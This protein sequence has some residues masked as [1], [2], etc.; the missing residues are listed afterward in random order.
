MFFANYPADYNAHKFI[1][2]FSKYG[3]MTGIFVPPAEDDVF[4]SGNPP[5]WAGY[6]IATFVN[7]ESANRCILSESGTKI[8]DHES[9]V[10]L[11]HWDCADK[12]LNDEDR[13]N[14]S[15]L[16]AH[17]R[18]AQEAFYHLRLPVLTLS[19]YSF[20][21]GLNEDLYK[22]L[23]PDN[24]GLVADGPLRSRQTKDF[25][26]D[27]FI[28]IVNMYWQEMNFPEAVA[29]YTATLILIGNDLSSLLWLL[30]TRCS[31]QQRCEVRN[32][33]H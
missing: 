1:D 30:D 10:R 7:A 8:P 26:I 5:T 23:S 20:E 29:P 21:D 22:L 9:C 3:R 19:S 4:D 17:V 15:N 28:P 11:F 12:R 32:V 14:L 27:I 2:I 24:D 33:A 31:C 16:E 13:T 25:F 18:L 6:G